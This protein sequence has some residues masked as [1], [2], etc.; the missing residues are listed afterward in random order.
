MAIEDGVLDLSFDR[1]SLYSEDEEGVPFHCNPDPS[2]LD[3]VPLQAVDGELLAVSE[4]WG[5]VTG[6]MK[7][8]LSE[9]EATS[10]CSCMGPCDGQAHPSC[11]GCPNGARPL[12]E[13]LGDISATDECS[14][15]LGQPAFDLHLALSANRIPVPPVCD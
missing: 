5:T 12:S 10:L 11:G 6:L 13:M 9:E 15:K 4:D 7:G 2:I 14:E 8:C 1:V 3:A